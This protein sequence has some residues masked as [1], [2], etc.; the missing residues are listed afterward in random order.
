MNLPT[1]EPIDENDPD[2]SSDSTGGR[3]RADV[4]QNITLPL[5]SSPPRTPGPVNTPAPTTKSGT[6]PQLVASRRVPTLSSSQ[7]MVGRAAGLPQPPANTPLPLSVIAE[8]SRPGERKYAITLAK[9]KSVLPVG[10]LLGLG[11]DEVIASED[12]I[13]ILVEDAAAGALSRR[14]PATSANSLMEAASASSRQR[15]PLRSYRSSFS[16]YARSGES[17]SRR[18]TRTKLCCGRARPRECGGA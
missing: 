11:G 3:L 8:G 6:L 2:F 12:F 10:R 14:F 1:G 17:R 15:F 13:R 16:Y 5:G 9:I 18:P 7:I 4:T